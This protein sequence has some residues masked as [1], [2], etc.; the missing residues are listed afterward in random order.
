MKKERGEGNLSDTLVLD[1]SSMIEMHN[2]ELV[3]KI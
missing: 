2:L 1:I 3:H